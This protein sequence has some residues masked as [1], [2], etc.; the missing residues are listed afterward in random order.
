LSSSPPLFRLPASST[1]RDADADT[2][3]IATC[4]CIRLP[5]RLPQRGTQRMRR[6]AVAV[7]HTLWCAPNLLSCS[8]FIQRRPLLIHRVRNA[9]RPEERRPPP[10]HGVC[11][12]AAPKHTDLPL[13]TQHV[14]NS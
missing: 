6:R 5:G 12:R 2:I 3:T 13:P 8:G 4:V 1:R 11:S 10:P 9:L 14:F 7:R